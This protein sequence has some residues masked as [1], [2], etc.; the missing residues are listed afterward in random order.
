MKKHAESNINTEPYWNAVYAAETEENRQRVDAVRLG[1]LERWVRVQEEETQRT[2]TVLDYGCGRG[3]A[4]F[5]LWSMGKQ[6]LLAGIDI[7]ATAIESAIDV[8]Y[9]L[10][11]HDAK[12]FTGAEALLDT[13]S[14]ENARFENGL[15]HSG[16]D[17]IWCGETLEHV[18]D[19][20]RIIRAFGRMLNDGGFLV[21]STPFK[22]R[23]RSDEHCWEFDPG[24]IADWAEHLGELVFL[25]CLLL[26]SWLTM[27]A[28]I[29]KGKRT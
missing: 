6:R 3:D 13:L 15:P 29:R 10:G 18:E 17:V 25:D 26:P 20:W 14:H 1:Q 22:G 7:S 2:A 11:A 24:D 19:P 5:G 16:F 21:L 23:N 9:G 27:F 8:R 4:I 12:F 28:V